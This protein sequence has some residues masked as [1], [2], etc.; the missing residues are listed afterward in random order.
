MNTQKTRARTSL[1]ST[2]RNTACLIAGITIAVSGVVATQTAEAKT[3]ASGSNPATAPLLAPA[4][5]VEKV[6]D[7]LIS[8][9]VIDMTDS[10]QG[11]KDAYLTN[12]A[13]KRIAVCAKTVSTSTVVDAKGTKVGTSKDTSWLCDVEVDDVKQS[14]RYTLNVVHS[15]GKTSKET[16]KLKLTPE[17][18]GMVGYHY[19]RFSFD[20]KG[21]STLSTTVSVGS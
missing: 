1:S 12:G 16:L 2:I 4:A 10:G 11:I 19:G 13:G 9:Y 5:P 15:D 17:A 20:S 3:P 7:V 8:A 18:A 21:L 14:A 6:A